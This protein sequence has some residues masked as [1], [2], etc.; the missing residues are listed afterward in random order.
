M[1]TPT[2]RAGS[3]TI[4]SAD[5][6][7]QVLLTLQGCSCYHYPITTPPTLALEQLCNLVLPPLTLQDP[8]WH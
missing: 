6:P 1:L 5:Y 3:R 2:F 7:F 4:S 8:T